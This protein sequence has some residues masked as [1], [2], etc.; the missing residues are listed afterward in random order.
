LIL[1]NPHKVSLSL[2]AIY[3]PGK[4]P[5]AILRRAADWDHS[6][7]RELDEKA[8]LVFF[9]LLAKSCVK[10]RSEEAESIISLPPTIARFLDVELIS[11]HHY[12]N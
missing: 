7:V 3:N 12:S 9:I 10:G 5:L 8:R 6:G 11:G 2:S 1:Q 4:A